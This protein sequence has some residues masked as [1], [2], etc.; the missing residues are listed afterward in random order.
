MP[1]ALYLEPGRSLFVGREDEV[2]ARFPE[3]E[4]SA[5]AGLLA[6]YDDE[7]RQLQE[8]LQQHGL[9]TYAKEI[10][11]LLQDEGVSSEQNQVMIE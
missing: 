6:A 7:N 4:P 1:P 5:V 2:A 3:L 9:D 8:A 10:V 11:R